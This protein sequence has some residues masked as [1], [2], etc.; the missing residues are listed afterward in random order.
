MGQRVEDED[1][2]QVA[3]HN[4]K[5]TQYL[6]R[7]LASP[8]ADSGQQ[9]WA[10]RELATISLS[11]IGLKQSYA[12]EIWLKE[13]LAD[14]PGSLPDLRLLAFTLS[15]IP[16]R[17]REAIELWEQV[18]EA[19]P[20]PSADDRYKLAQLYELSGETEKA[21]E[22]LLILGTTAGSHPD[23][24]QFVVDYVNTLIRKS[25]L[26]EAETWI[27]T[28]RDNPRLRPTM[29]RLTAEVMARRGQ[30]QQA[31]D[32]LSAVVKLLKSDASDG[33]RALVTQQIA[34]WLKE[35]SQIRLK[36]AGELE[37][38]DSDAAE[39]AK[40]YVRAADSL[41]RQA[42]EL[43]PSGKLALA[44]HLAVNEDFDRALELVES[45]AD[46]V[47]VENMRADFT[48]HRRVTFGHQPAVGSGRPIVAERCRQTTPLPQLG[49]G[50]RPTQGSPR[51]LR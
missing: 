44:E 32:T 26:T 41:V 3:A 23:H 24:S 28:L 35:L 38:G 17:Q 30:D 39:A 29:A 33:D 36:I 20:N 21:S 47:A 48:D 14:S 7:L 11:T 25:E 15:R 8:E 40:L 6:E 9:I 45:I 43:A 4:E 46:E 12:A 31:I 2:E 16:A 51:P 22:I 13:N 42:A 10:R 50:D 49:D 18:I 19:S 27:D 5:A 37:S 1:V 34:E